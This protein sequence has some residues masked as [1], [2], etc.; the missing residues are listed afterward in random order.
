MTRWM[1]EIKIGGVEKRGCTTC[2]FTTEDPTALATMLDSLNQIPG[3][4]RV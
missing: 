1:K 3:K 4:P 2:T